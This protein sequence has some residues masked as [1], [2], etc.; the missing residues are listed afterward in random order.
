VTGRTPAERAGGRSEAES[1]DFSR[2]GPGTLA[3][4]YMRR[5]WQPV[6][7]AGELAPGHAV[8]IRL[9]GEDLT[10]YRGE[11]GVPHVLAFRCAHRGMQLSAGWVEG[12][13]LRCS[14]HGWMYDGSGQCVQQPAEDP[15]F[16]AKVR[17]AAYPTREYLGLVFTFLGDA[18]TP[19]PRYPW[20]E[21]GL[22]RA[23]GVLQASSY[24]RRCNYFQNVENNV[25]EL[26]LPFTHRTSGYTEHGLNAD[27]PRV[28]AEETD[29]GMVQ[30][31]HRTGEKVRT[32]HYLM[33][34]MIHFR[35]SPLFPFETDWRDV[36]SYR[37]P[38]DDVSHRSPVIT[39]V[40][41]RPEDVA[42]YEAEQARVR[43]QLAGLPSQD[44]VADAVLS[45][46]VRMQDIPDRPDLVLIQDHIAQEGQGAIVDRAAERLGRSDAAIVLLRKIWRRELEALAEGRPLKTWADAPDLAA[47]RGT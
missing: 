12:D 27:L 14:Y 1:A 47:T 17:L 11:S 6:H 39:L 16:A 46:R 45:G 31:G 22:E 26:H 15:A 44:E 41:V 29:Y 34:T 36:L 2:T 20:F 9:M 43:A 4:R 25:D 30:Y 33:P 18:P 42:R 38:I 21:R 24:T 32:S 5:F 35:A 7:L 37:V 28:E 13:C 19:L 40:H 10:L 8:P 3:G 23:D